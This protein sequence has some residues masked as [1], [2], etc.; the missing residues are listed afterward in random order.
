MYNDRDNPPA[1]ELAT[2]FER[3]TDLNLLQEN[4]RARGSVLIDLLGVQFVVNP[5][6]TAKIAPVIQRA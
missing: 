1:N 3:G 6:S 2:N 5:P 4:A